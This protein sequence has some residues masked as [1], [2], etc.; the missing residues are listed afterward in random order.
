MCNER[1]TSDSN[2]MGLERSGMDRGVRGTA[3]SGFS[4]KTSDSFSQDNRFLF[5]FLF[6][7]TPQE[8]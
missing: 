5:L 1:S 4:I 6:D 7:G 2:E 8:K 3:H